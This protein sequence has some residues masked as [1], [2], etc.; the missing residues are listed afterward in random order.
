[1]LRLFKEAVNN[2]LA[3]LALVVIV[4]LQNLL[5]GQGVDAVAQI[6]QTNGALFALCCAW[7]VTGLGLDYQQEDELTLS[8]ASRRVA[9]TMIA[10]VAATGT[11]GAASSTRWRRSGGC[12]LEK[13]VANRG[14]EMVGSDFLSK[15]K[16]RIAYR[17]SICLVTTT[18]NACY[19]WFW[20]LVG[21]GEGGGL[22]CVVNTPCWQITRPMSPVI[23]KPKGANGQGR[24][25]GWLGTY[26]HGSRYNS[27]VGIH[28]SSRELI[29]GIGRIGIRLLLLL[30]VVLPI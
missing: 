14:S 9:S 19:L 24:G 10:K 1:L 4:H 29:L 18:V 25:G 23:I 20:M 17:G 26:I 12:L 28:G 30:V 16:L 5:K 7:S 6:W 11:G 27:P 3:E 8:S 15:R 2:R 21:G 13:R 22:F